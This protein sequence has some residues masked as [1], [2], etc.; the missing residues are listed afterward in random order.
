MTVHNNVLILSCL[1]GSGHEAARKAIEEEFGDKYKFTTYYPF[2]DFQIS[3]LVDSE[4]FYNGMVRRGFNRAINYLASCSPY[5]LN[6]FPGSKIAEKTE[7]LIK[8]LKPVCV[9][10]LA[11]IINSQTIPICAKYKVPYCLVT[12]DADLTNWTIGLEKIKN[13]VKNIWVTIGAN[14]PQ[15]SGMLQRKQIHPK[16]LHTIG[17][18]IRKEFSQ[19]RSSRADLCHQLNLD[20]NRPIIM[21]MWGG[22][23]SDRMYPIMSGLGQEHRGTQFVAITGKNQDLAERMKTIPIHSSNS[24]RVLG[25]THQVADYMEASDILITKPGPGTYSEAAAV[26]QKT[27]RPYLLLDNDPAC[28][29]WEKPIIDIAI[30]NGIGEAFSTEEELK[31]KIARRLLDLDRPSHLKGDGN[32]FSAHIV[33]IIDKMVQTSTPSRLKELD[34]Q[35]F[36]ELFPA[37]LQSLLSNVEISEPTQ[38]LPEGNYSDPHTPKNPTSLHQALHDFKDINHQIIGL[39]FHID[40]SGKPGLIYLYKVPGYAHWNIFV[41]TP[42]SQTEA[43][44]YEPNKISWISYFLSYPTYQ[45]TFFKNLLEDKHPHYRLSSPPEIWTCK[46]KRH[47]YDHT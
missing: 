44:Y 10:S 29:F 33:E 16:E 15:T 40:C 38:N 35:Q 41:R 34:R 11:P 37:E 45:K 28:L 4:T 5:F 46:L 17:F 6:A 3:R 7:A 30:E 31:V 18:P 39:T 20:P 2:K 36:L 19:A 13:L 26:H 14:I 43:V 21:L 1:G 12:L 42:E 32:Q 9:I 8:E 24:L 47:K 25:F 23:G 22:A 27:G